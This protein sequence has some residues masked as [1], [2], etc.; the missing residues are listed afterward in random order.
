MPDKTPVSD[1]FEKGKAWYQS[2]TIIGVIIT[3]VGT[4]LSAVKPEWAIDFAGVTEVVLEDGKTIAKEA[5]SIWASVLTLVGILTTTW[6]RIKAKTPI[7]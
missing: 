5:D 1:V 6:G 7:K 2:R 4:V 3:L